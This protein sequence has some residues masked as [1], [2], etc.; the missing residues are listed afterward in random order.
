[1]SGRHNKE[2][3]GART[4]VLN[5]EM[6]CIFRVGNSTK[7]K[8]PKLGSKH[9]GA[10]SCKSSHKGRQPIGSSSKGTPLC[11]AG[12]DKDI[13]LSD[14]SLQSDDEDYVTAAERMSDTEEALGE[15]EC[16][17]TEGEGE[18]GS[19]IFNTGQQGNIMYCEFNYKITLS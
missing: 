2:T 10:Q 13:S 19:S 14:T 17:D 5:D 16:L 3:K 9:K 6:W 15:E 4:C 12:C 7:T 1:M 8:T 18:E 11:K